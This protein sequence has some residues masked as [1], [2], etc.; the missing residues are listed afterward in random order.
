MARSFLFGAKM[1]PITSLLQEVARDL[2]EE[3]AYWRLEDKFQ[4]LLTTFWNPGWPIHM[5]SK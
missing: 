2:K 3:M 4:A 5:F 1:F